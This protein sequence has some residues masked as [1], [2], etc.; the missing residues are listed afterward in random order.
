MPTLFLNWE[1]SIIIK[2]FFAEHSSSNFEG[3]HPTFIRQLS[4]DNESTQSIDY[5]AN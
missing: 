1:S 2:H 5:S 4:G 3:L